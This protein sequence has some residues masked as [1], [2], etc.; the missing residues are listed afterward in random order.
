M[1][2]VFL[3]CCALAAMSLIASSC[4]DDN[5]EAN[6]PSEIVLMVGE[7]INLNQG[8]ESENPF[9]AFVENAT[10]TGAH[11]G[12][13]VLKIG[14]F[15]IP[16]SVLGYYHLYDDPITDWGCSMATVKQR[17]KQGTLNAASST[18]EQL[19]YTE[20]G[21]AK[22]LAYTFK[23]NKLVSINA[24]IQPSNASNIGKHLA[25]R[26]VM[27]P[28]VTGELLLIGIDAYDEERATTA[29]SVSVPS[30]ANMILV[31]YIPYS[32]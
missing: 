26:Y 19:V 8:A 31:T 9:V 22:I 10:L 16:V 30:S 6:Y 1:K 17:Q 23:N 27:T 25:E 24:A 15:R 3:F 7:K 2:K 21:A 28:Y 12:S 13:T 4:A 5:E 18:S 14:K 29:V 32:H 11:I 20:A